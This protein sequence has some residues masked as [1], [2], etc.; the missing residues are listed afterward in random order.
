VTTVPAAPP[1]SIVVLSGTTMPAAFRPMNAMNSPMPAPTAILSWCGIALMMAPRTPVTA[2]IRN[3][4]PDTNVPA[5]AVS[6]GIPKVST[7][8]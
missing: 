7:T 4:R 3:S 1:V 2:R 8:V 5:R 6:H